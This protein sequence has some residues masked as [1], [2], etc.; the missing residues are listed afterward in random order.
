MIEILGIIGATIVLLSMAIPSTHRRQNI[1]MR[2]INIV[3]STILVVYSFKLNAYSTAILNI[4]ANGVNLY[5][6]I[7][8]LISM[9]KDGKDIFKIERN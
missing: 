4:I 9:K 3:G 1:A 2:C 5:H 7:K 8:L 6:I